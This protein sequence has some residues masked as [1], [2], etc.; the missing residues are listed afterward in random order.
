MTGPMTGAITREMTTARERPVGP[1]ATKG[2][3]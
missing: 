1:M 2:Q 3:H